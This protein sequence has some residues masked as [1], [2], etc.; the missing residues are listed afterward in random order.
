MQ[1]QV[2]SL[3]ELQNKYIYTLEAARAHAQ[4]QCFSCDIFPFIANETIKNYPAVCKW[5]GLISII[6]LVIERLDSILVVF[7]EHHA[8]QKPKSNC[9]KRSKKI[10]S[11]RK[12]IC[13]K[14]KKS[15]QI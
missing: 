2:Q 1:L 15:N 4:F 5:N 10:H 3:T 11:H 12:I 7:Y 6:K 14:L 9:Q 13:M 8:C